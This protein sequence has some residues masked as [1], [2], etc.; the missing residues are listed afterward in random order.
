MSFNKILIIRL[1]SIGDIVL[2]SPVIRALKEQTDASI[3]FLTKESYVHVI[4]NNPFIQK[5]FSISEIAQVL[6]KKFDLI[7][8]LQKNL[9]SIFISI[10][11]KDKMKNTL[12]IS[13][14][15]EN[16]KKWIL[17]NFKKNFLKYD[18][19]VDRYF[20]E[21]KKNNIKNDNKGLDFFISTNINKKSF[22]KELPLE[23]SYI[24][25]VIGGTY[26]QKKIS[27]EIII[28]VCSTISKPVILIGGRLEKQIGEY[29]C[30]KAKKENLYNLCG[31]LSL[32]ESAFII[33][34][35]SIV[36]TNDTGMMHIACAF[37]KKII[38]FWGCT[39][40]SLGMY[41]YI[42][43]ENSIKINSN[44][45]SFP[46]SKLGNKCLYSKDGCI[47]NIK[48]KEILKAIEKMT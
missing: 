9:K 48:F 34:N 44:I 3:Y 14:N 5:V 2:T 31:S 22:S 45:S 6:N 20:S 16:I 35:S 19:V 47:N 11:I 27:K 1:S 7:V 21:L 25:W 42:S 28:K 4:S 33:K 30:K 46:C 8:D 37:Q 32:D 15:K 13:Y 39:K 43:N 36:L 23:N 38:S 24:V 12:Y 41:P 10:L 18:H 26:K 40:P 29:I 17:I